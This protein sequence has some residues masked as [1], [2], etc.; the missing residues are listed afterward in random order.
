MCCF[1]VVQVID[2]K[3]VSLGSRGGGSRAF[4]LSEAGGQNPFTRLL[5]ASRSSSL[6]FSETLLHS[7]LCFHLQISSDSA[8]PSSLDKDPVIG[9]S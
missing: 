4:S 2:V 1:T 6:L 5:P 7:D 8:P 9:P 3:S